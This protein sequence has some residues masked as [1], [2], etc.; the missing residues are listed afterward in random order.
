MPCL[1]TYESGFSTQ[2]TTRAMFIDGQPT[3][4]KPLIQG[5]NQDGLLHLYKRVKD[6]RLLQDFVFGLGKNQEQQKNLF[7]W[8]EKETE[9]TYRTQY[10]SITQLADNRMPERY[11]PPEAYQYDFFEGNQSTITARRGSIQY[12]NACK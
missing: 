2:T 4:E 10:G 6:T 7:S 1:K 12:V 3:T 8:C 11:T 5:S 9:S